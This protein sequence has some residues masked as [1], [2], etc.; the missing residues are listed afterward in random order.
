MT[1]PRTCGRTH[2][3][4]VFKRI[5]NRPP[6]PPNGFCAKYPTTQRNPALT[7][8]LLRVEKYGLPKTFS[9]T[10]SIAFASPSKSRP[11]QNVYTF[12]NGRKSTRY[13]Y[14]VEY[15]THVRLH[16]IR[17]SQHCGRSELLFWRVRSQT[18]R[19]HR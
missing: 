2:A 6:H 7:Q 13:T 9:L 17:V 5:S 14:T 4:S 16:C 10:V 8:I 3:P 19:F 15:F 11:T 18:V 12:V 1:W